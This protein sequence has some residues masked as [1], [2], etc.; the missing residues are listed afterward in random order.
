MKNHRV[1]I[2][3]NG[4]IEWS[5]DHFT[6]DSDD[7]ALEL[8][9]LPGDVIVDG[10]GLDSATFGEFHKG[11]LRRLFSH[12]P[13]RLYE[14]LDETARVTVP[15]DAVP[16]APDHET[17]FQVEFRRIVSRPT[18]EALDVAAG[19]ARLANA[20]ERRAALAEGREPKLR[21]EPARAWWSEVR[22]AEGQTKRRAVF[23]A[24][25]LVHVFEGGSPDLATEDA[26]TLTEGD[27]LVGRRNLGTGRP[28]TPTPIT[29]GGKP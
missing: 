3:R 26:H 24:A 6:P 8:P 11:T 10:A 2:I 13:E 22:T 18:L 17:V 12:D 7:N 16:A 27:V 25:R 19:E 1:F 20:R 15:A 4:H 23:P 28:G 14:L 9:V 21:A 29:L 5:Y